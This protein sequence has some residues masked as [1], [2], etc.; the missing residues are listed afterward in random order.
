MNKIK[1]E[2]KI[3][4]INRTFI[5]DETYNL[6]S[7]KI[8]SGDL[9][10]CQRLRVKELSDELGISRT[11]VRE[12]LLQLESEGLVL[13]K[14]NRWTIVAPI[15][16]KEALNIYPIIYS[17]EELALEEAFDKI[18]PKEISK[19]REINDRIK[20]LHDK[21]DQ[22]GIIKKDN[23]FHN[24]ITN[25]SGN[26]EIGPILQKLKRRVERM[27][28]YFFE[29]SESNF[30]TYIEHL[31]IIESLEEGKLEKSK[32]SLVRNW[33]STIETIVN[34]SKEI[35]IEDNEISN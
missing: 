26:E 33:T 19:L 13:T 5:K 4:K 17:L 27:E 12:A 10:P 2:S 3:G 34:L 28:L 31:K 35:N 30:T 11:P 25:L 18:G 9:R 32:K 22:L 29:N 8:I 16:P 7:Q 1:T 23:E 20:D 15:N 14:A 24:Y 6:L 21:S